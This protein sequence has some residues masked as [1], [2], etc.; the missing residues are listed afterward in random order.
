MLGV[1]GE[2][3]TTTRP[4]AAVHGREPQVFFVA[5]GPDPFLLRY[6]WGAVMPGTPWR[7]N[8][9]ASSSDCQSSH[10]GSDVFKA[11]SCG[12]NSSEDVST[13]AANSN[14][15]LVSGDVFSSRSP[16]HGVDVGA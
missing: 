6:N 2:P 13:F 10:A 16:P 14:G 15:L 1:D 3:S 5:A 12:A 4:V 11:L 9:N 7:T 8:R